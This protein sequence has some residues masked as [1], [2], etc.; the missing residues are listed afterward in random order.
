MTRWRAR[1]VLLAAGLALAAGSLPEPALAAAARKPTAAQRA[2]EKRRRAAAQRE[3]LRRQQEALKKAWQPEKGCYQA[4]A[5]F[6]EP[7]LKT[8][9]PIEVPPSAR[10]G[11]MKAALFMYEANVDTRGQLHSLRT[12]R[13]VPAE[14]PWP[15]LQDAVVKSVK[16]WRWNRTK[17]AGKYIAVCFPL[18]LNVDLR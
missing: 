18:T 15:L 9:H 14:P 5:A 12:V 13:P 10:G 17:V 8:N 16:T 4:G 1:A 11:A 6:V 7:S 2:A 3:A